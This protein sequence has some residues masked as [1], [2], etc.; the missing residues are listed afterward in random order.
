[1]NS[2]DVVM[3]PDYNG[4]QEEVIVWGHIVTAHTFFK[5]LKISDKMIEIVQYSLNYLQSDGK[6]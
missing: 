1:M 4:D 2:Q 3:E 6:L 5:C